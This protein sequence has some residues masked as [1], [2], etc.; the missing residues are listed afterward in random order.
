MWF[1]FERSLLHGNLQVVPLVQEVLAAQ[2][3]LVVRVVLDKDFVRILAT[4][5]R[6]QENNEGKRVLTQ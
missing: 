1:Y 5:S 6:D 2:E 3:V 4:S